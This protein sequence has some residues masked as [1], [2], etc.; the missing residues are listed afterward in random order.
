MHLLIQ[1]AKFRTMFLPF[2]PFCYTYR[3]NLELHLVHQSTDG[4][5]AVVGIMYKI[6]RPD[7]LLS[8]VSQLK[9]L[10]LH[11]IRF[12]QIVFDQHY[13]LDIRIFLICDQMEPYF[14][15]LAS[16]KD[17]EKSVGVIDPREIKVGSRKYY[18]YIGSLTT[19]PCT[20]NV[21]WTIVNK[22]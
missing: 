4:K 10:F 5:I 11:D 13:N 2:F 12:T 7:S 16:T 15:A 8:V 1:L 22:V 17:V 19:P 6:G 20:Q 3:F 18:R 9:N 14:K 21:I